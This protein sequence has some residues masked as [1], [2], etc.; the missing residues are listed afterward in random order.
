M[1]D[2][3]GTM[4]DAGDT[5]VV[6]SHKLECGDV[7]Q[8]VEVRYNTYGMLNA[9]KDNALVV[10]HALTGNSSLDGWWGSMLGPGKPFDTD[11][12]FVVCANIL[13]GCYGT[14]GPASTNPHTG[15]LYQSDFPR[16]SVRDSV[17]LHMKL[18]QDG[19]G[20]TQVQSVVGGSMGGMQ[21]LEWMLLG[22]ESGYVRSGVPISCGAHHHAWQIAISESQRSAIY[23][24]PKYNGGFYNMA[25]PPVGG[26]GVARQIAMVT[27][28]SHQ[29][30]EKKFGR[31]RHGAGSLFSVESY[32]RHQGEKF[33]ARFDPNSY[34]TVTQ[35]M[36]SHDVGRGRGGEE[37][38]LRALQIPV[39]V[40]GIDSDALY[41]ISEQYALARMIPHSELHILRSDE[42]HDG[43]LL[44]QQ[45]IGPLLTEFLNKVDGTLPPS[46]KL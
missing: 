20:V 1:S 14:T 3:Y 46:S 2:E 39:M 12:Y 34:V 11:K 24:D 25:D 38:A 30:Y 43:F 9:R 6:Q 42:G 32:L 41:P 19:L 4:D 13:G 15:A 18:L 27:Y 5:F 10:C 36:D 35:L 22:N 7:L 17:R 23:A 37:Q 40:I 44:E 29:A 45:Q 8:D 33:N 16:V 26:L 21:T 28:R 31:M